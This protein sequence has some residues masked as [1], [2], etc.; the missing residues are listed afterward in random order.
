MLVFMRLIVDNYF[1]VDNL[2]FFPW[3]SDD[4]FNKIFTLIDRV[5]EDDDIASL[6]FAYGYQGV[7][8]K[9]D[10]DPIYEFIDKDVVAYQ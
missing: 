3:Q 6:G 10:F 8:A 4:A 9:R 5:Y 7:P 2:Y 1:F